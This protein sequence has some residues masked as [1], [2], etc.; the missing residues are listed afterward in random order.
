MYRK[1]SWDPWI[2]EYF[3]NLPKLNQSISAPYR[4]RNI[5]IS[6]LIASDFISS[7]DTPFQH[8]F[9]IANISYKPNLMINSINIIIT[10]IIKPFRNPSD[11]KLVNAHTHI[12]NY[13]SHDLS[14]DLIFFLIFYYIIHY[15]IIMFLE[16]RAVSNF[17]RFFFCPQFDSFSVVRKRR[18]LIYKELCTCVF[19]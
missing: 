1:Q 2:E 17:H 4:F 9:P 7:K 6:T 16:S 8:H 13:L 12:Q 11:L 3:H 5:I 15:I 18:V 19:K 14:H 10:I